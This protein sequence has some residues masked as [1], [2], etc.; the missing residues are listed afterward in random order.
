MSNVFML[1]LILLILKFATLP[2]IRH[3][4]PTVPAMI[5]LVEMISKHQ[6]TSRLHELVR[7]FNQA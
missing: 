4:Q 6:I 5:R 3:F 7:R 2:T 1:V